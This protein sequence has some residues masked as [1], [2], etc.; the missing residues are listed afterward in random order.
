MFVSNYTLSTVIAGKLY[1][2]HIYPALFK[3]IGDCLVYGDVIE[4]LVSWRGCE[5]VI[6]SGNTVSGLSEYGA[7]AKFLFRTIDTCNI[8]QFASMYVAHKRMIPHLGCRMFA[9]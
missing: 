2:L 4:R 7:G 1:Y 8:K 9:R 5:R 6:W 3:H